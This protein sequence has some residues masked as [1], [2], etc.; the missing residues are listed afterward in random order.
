ML[1]VSKRWTEKTVESNGNEGKN[2]TRDVRCWR[3]MPFK[4]LCG[5]HTWLKTR[6][7]NTQIQSMCVCHC[8]P[9]HPR[10]NKYP[11]FSDC[12]DKWRVKNSEHNKLNG[13]KKQQHTKNWTKQQQK[14]RQIQTYT[15]YYIYVCVC[16]YRHHQ[17]QLHYDVCDIAEF[18]LKGR[19][20]TKSKLLSIWLLCTTADYYYLRP[21]KTYDVEMEREKEQERERECKKTCTLIKIC[22]TCHRP[23]YFLH[24]FSLSP[25]AAP[26]ISLGRCLAVGFVCMLFIRL[27]HS[28]AHCYFLLFFHIPQNDCSEKRRQLMENLFKNYITFFSVLKSLKRVYRVCVCVCVLSLTLIHWHT[29]SVAPLL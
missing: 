27:L 14:R 11:D 29:F 22:K 15:I 20:L 18:S 10:Y 26:S 12:I 17:R 2:S 23:K 9:S 19:N 24:L 21:V 25:S 6:T 7:S 1:I 16:V 3:F 28:F 8:V 4:R 5:M 13:G